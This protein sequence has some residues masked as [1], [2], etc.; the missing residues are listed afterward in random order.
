MREFIYRI[1]MFFHAMQI[2]AYEKIDVPT[3]TIKRKMVGTR[4]KMKLQKGYQKAAMNRKQL[5]K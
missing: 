4:K 3:R 5:R 2:V 1:A